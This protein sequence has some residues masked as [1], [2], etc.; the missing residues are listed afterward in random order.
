MFWILLIF[1]VIRY[2]IN[3]ERDKVVYEW[4]NIELVVEV[5]E[6]IWWG[7]KMV[8]NFMIYLYFNSNIFGFILN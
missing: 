4:V 7:E 8:I 5:G 2:G 3:R 6:D 1:F